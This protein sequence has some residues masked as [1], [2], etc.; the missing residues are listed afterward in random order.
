MATQ[1][2]R[3]PSGPDPA[4]KNPDL[5]L[6]ESAMEFFNARNFQGARESF[7]TLTNSANARSG[8][9]RRTT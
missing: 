8:L 3:Q 6:Y 4:T 2:K 5:H 9:Q 1:V 7:L